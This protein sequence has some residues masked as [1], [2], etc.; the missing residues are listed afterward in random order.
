[1]TDTEILDW[2]IEHFPRVA[3]YVGQDREPFFS[4]IP[5]FNHPPIHN[6]DFRECVRIAAAV[7]KMENS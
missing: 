1:M 2:Y 4:M 6:K 7:L 3:K 5:N